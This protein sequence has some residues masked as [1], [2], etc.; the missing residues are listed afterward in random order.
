MK[1]S[2]AHDSQ[3]LESRIKIKPNRNDTK[4]RNRET[5]ETI[6]S[7]AK[8]SKGKQRSK[9]VRLSGWKAS[10]KA[11]NGWLADWLTSNSF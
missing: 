2:N 9:L 4:T 7:K 6:E 3:L 8:R 10:K 11:S 1:M 5:D